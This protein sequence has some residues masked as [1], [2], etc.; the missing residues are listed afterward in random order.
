MGTENGHVEQIQ[1]FLRRNAA[2]RFAGDRSF[3]YGKSTANQRIEA[4]WGILRKEQAQFW[5]ELNGE[6]KNDGVFDGD[7]L[8]KGL[9]Q[10]CFMKLIQVSVAGYT[11]FLL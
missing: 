1:R 11:S 7:V 2:D 8:D 10:F 4:W 5:I 6:L 9:I 3:L